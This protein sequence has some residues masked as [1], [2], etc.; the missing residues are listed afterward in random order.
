M[1]FVAGMYLIGYNAKVC[2]QTAEG[3]VFDRTMFKR[4][5]TGDWMGQAAQD[6]IHMGMDLASMLTF[7]EYDAAAMVD[8]IR[9]YNGAA[10]NIQTAY[11]G[12]LDVKHGVAKSLVLTSLLT[13]TII[14]ANGGTG[15][16]SITPATRTLPRTILAENYPVRELFGA[17]LRDLPIKFRHY[18][19][20]RTQST[21]EGG[22]EYGTET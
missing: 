17:N 10:T 21:G 4:L 14:N 2:G 6:G 11:P 5:I 8:I 19:T 15:A 1:S 18:P 22:G 3:I 9:P 12:V 20:Q 7:L 13:G 16:S